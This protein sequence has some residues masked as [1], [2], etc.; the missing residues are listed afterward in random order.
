MVGGLSEWGGRITLLGGSSVSGLSQ[1]T[2]QHEIV[3]ITCTFLCKTLYCRIFEALE[4]RHIESTVQNEAPPRHKILQALR[5]ASYSDEVLNQSY[6]G[7]QCARA[8]RRP[9]HPGSR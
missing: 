5:V 6:S 2:K 8:T 9:G 3:S 4:T 7:H 1:T